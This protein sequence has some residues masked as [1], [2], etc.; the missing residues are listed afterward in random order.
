[1]SSSDYSD[2]SRDDSSEF[3]TD[4]SVVLDL[5]SDSPSDIDSDVEVPEQESDKKPSWRKYE[6]KETLK[7]RLSL[8]EIVSRIFMK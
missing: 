7:K 6:A 2:T 3:D 5:I 1:M 4:R 8:K